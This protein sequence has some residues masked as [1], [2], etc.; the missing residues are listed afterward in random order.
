MKRSDKPVVAVDIG[1]TKFIA[2]IIDRKGKMLSRVY[3]LTRD[4]DGPGK[5]IKRLTATI[6]EAIETAG[7]D[8]KGIGAISMAAAGIIDIKRGVI[9]ESPNLQGWRNI[10]LDSVLGREFA[11]PVFLLNDASAAALGEQC[12]GA[13]AGINNLIYI[14]VSTGIGG[15]FIINGE[16]YNGASGSAA[17]IGHMIIRIDGPRC[18]CGQNGC[19]EAMASGTAMSR[20][21][22]ERIRKGESSLLLDMAGGKLPAVTA[23]LIARAARRKDPLALSVIEEAAYYLGIGM[24]NLVNLLNPQMIIIGGGVS[25]MGS[26]LLRPARK[27]MKEHAFKLPS[28]SVRVVKSR[29]GAD[30]GIYGAA[31]YAY[32][33]TGAGR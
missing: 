12:F 19:L 27:S 21:A 14:T 5:V 29:L 20:M 24:S 28:S 30:A 1:G 2:A 18:N 10:S 6:H 13:G 25:A 31:A 4:E 3:K 32:S 9:T 16:L 33:R 22:V 8:I 23:Q 17:E 15:G 7:L 11:L 26:M